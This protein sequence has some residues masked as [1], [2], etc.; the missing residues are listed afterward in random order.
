M[1]AT[2]FVITQSLVPG[3]MAFWDPDAATM[4]ARNRY[5]E[6]RARQGREVVIGYDD[7]DPKICR[8]TVPIGAR[9]VW[10][11]FDGTN[12]VAACATLEEARMKQREM[13]EAYTSNY[14]I[15]DEYEDPGYESD[16]SGEFAVHLHRTI[17]H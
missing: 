4:V 11:V 16:A 9:H 3:S 7:Y 6:E 12:I 10:I 15:D 1:T 13:F 5:H 14:G 2:A 17:I 8:V